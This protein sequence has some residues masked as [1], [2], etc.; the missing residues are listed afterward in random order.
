[1]TQSKGRNYTAEE[2]QLVKE[3]EAFYGIDPSQVG[4][5]FENPGEPIFD[6]TAISCLSLKLTDIHS[7]ECMIV[8]RDK[9]PGTATASCAVTLPDGRNRAVEASA[10]IGETLHDGTVITT[11][12]LAESVAQSRAS[13]L[14]IRSVGI[15]LVQAHRNYVKTGNIAQ[16]HTNHDPLKPF[17]DEVHVLAENLGFIVGSDRSEWTNFLAETFAGK[18][19]SK[20]LDT[21][22]RNNLLTTLRALDRVRRSRGK[23]SAAA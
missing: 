2:L 22:E 21:G 17:Y 19:S 4:F 5:D 11:W 9:D 18:Q 6:Y 16:G 1:M 14:G 10:E 20:D 3:F 12:Q 7:I 13:R 15:N 8:R 23:Q